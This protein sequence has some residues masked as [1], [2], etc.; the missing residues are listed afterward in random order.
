MAH[1]VKSLGGLNFVYE[2]TNMEATAAMPNLHSPALAASVPAYS[3]VR[4]TETLSIPL[5]G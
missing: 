2:V 4:G 1:L 3:I 5:G